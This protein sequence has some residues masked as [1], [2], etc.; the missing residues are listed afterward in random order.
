[1]LWKHIQEE[2][3]PDLGWF[4]RGS[5]V[6]EVQ[7]GRRELG[8]WRKGC[9][10]VSSSLHI[11]PSR[12]GGQAGNLPLGSPKGSSGRSW[13]S[14]PSEEPSIIDLCSQTGFQADAGLPPLRSGSFSCFVKASLILTHRSASASVSVSLALLGDTQTDLTLRLGGTGA[15]SSS[16]H[17][18]IGLL[19]APFCSGSKLSAQR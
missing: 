7:P 19:A 8:R 16:Y 15:A 12:S 4:H 9:S 18:L 2:E 5:A 17:S 6:L 11:C 13:R 1:M 3:P 14:E 10:F